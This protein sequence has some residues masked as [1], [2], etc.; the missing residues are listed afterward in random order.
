M[1]P[2]S[3]RLSAHANGVSKLHGEVSRKMWQSIWPRTPVEDTP[4]DSVTNGIH[5]STWASREIS[6]LYNRYMGQD[7]K[8][9][10]DPVQIWKYINQIPLSEIWRAH[11][12]C[13]ERLVAFS[14]RAFLKQLKRQGAPA[15]MLTAAMEVLS[16]D[17]LTIGFARRFATYKRAT[18]LFSDTSRLAKILNNADR[19]VQIII[20]GKAHPADNDG[21]AFIKQVIHYSREERFHSR[22]LFLENYNIHLAC[23]L[24]AGCD[25]WLNNPRRPLEA[26][27]TSGMKALA[28]GVLNL[29][30]LDGW[31][32]EGYG[33]DYGWAI[34]SGEV[35]RDQ[36]LQDITESQALYI[37]L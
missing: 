18:L 11:C 8:E 7:W 37:L 19:P 4:I 36:Q 26:C 30:V 20:A 33:P 5:V 27:G 31:W 2:L 12:H 1:T 23:L 32:D 3:L 34:G 25:V 16:P 28:N 35:E 9:D 6:R 17:T 10:P 14:R 15:D 13:R 29:S 24:T 22:I 21:K